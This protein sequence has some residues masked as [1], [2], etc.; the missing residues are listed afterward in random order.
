MDPSGSQILLFIKRIFCERSRFSVWQLPALPDA[1]SH[2]C[3][4]L[5]GSHEP[6]FLMWKGLY[7]FQGSS[8]FFSTVR[9]RSKENPGGGTGPAS[10]THC[11]QTGSSRPDSPMTKPGSYHKATEE[12]RAPCE[13][14]LWL[15]HSSGC[16]PQS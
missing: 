7:L 2:R 14:S 5:P 11:L 12:D 6:H 8:V 13:K 9:L 3:H 16:V 15:H 4:Q 1:A 10:R